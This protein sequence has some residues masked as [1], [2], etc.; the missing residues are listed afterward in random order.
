VAEELE[1]ADEHGLVDGVLP[2]QPVESFTKSSNIHSRVDSLYRLGRSVE[3][4]FSWDS[5]VSQ[6]KFPGEGVYEF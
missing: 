2:P 1:G 6:I 4:Y 5:E 3:G